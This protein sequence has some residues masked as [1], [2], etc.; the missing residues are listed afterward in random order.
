MFYLTLGFKNE[1]SVLPPHLPAPHYPAC[2]PVWC[3]YT[4]L[5]FQTFSKVNKT[6]F[7]SL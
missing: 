3:N 6:L 4:G 5:V 1:G 2:L 7:C